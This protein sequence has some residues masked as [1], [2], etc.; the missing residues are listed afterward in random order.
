M[1]LHFAPIL[2]PS[3]KAGGL[4]SLQSRS[5]RYH[6]LI[7][8]ISPQ[9][10]LAPLCDGSLVKNGLWWYLTRCTYYCQPPRPC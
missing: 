1:I 6:H 5:R 8:H 3:S 4:P 2:L 9:D 7:Y 10:T